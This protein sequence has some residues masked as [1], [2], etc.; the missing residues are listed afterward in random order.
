M[1]ERL[2][3]GPGR[4][5]TAVY[6]VFALA[7]TGRSAYQLIADPG[8]APLAYTLS[9]FA[10][11]VY[12]VAT[13]CLVT[14]RRTIAIAAVAIELVGVFTVGAISFAA[15]DLFPDKTVW[16]HFG[17]GYGYL[18]ALLPLLGLWWL[19]RGSRRSS[20]DGD[21]AASR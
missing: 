10:A 15:T 3:S 13:V 8:R 21:A 2:S 16:S 19:L 7:A 4:I 14:G 11:A 5:L 18:P 6:A 1:S 17:Q 20:D 12:V 9:A